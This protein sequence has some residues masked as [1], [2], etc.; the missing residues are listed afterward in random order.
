MKQIKISYKKTKK[1]YS[2]GSWLPLMVHQE[3]PVALRPCL[4]TSLPFIVSSFM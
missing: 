1:A 4:S 2:F 3:G